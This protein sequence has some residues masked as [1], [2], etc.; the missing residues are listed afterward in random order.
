MGFKVLCEILMNMCAP[1]TDQAPA[2]IKLV[3]DAR[4]IE[5]QFGRA[6]CPKYLQH[7]TW[8]YITVDRNG[9]VLNVWPAAIF[10]PKEKL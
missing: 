7:N 2:K 5:S 3:F 9:L 4:G 10:W 8:C 1:A 6:P